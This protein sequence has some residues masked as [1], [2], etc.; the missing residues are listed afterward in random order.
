L[1]ECEEKLV[2]RKSKLFLQRFGF[3]VKLCMKFFTSLT[4]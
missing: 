3:D 2:I 4:F 1:L